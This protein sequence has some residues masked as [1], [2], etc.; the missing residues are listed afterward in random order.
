MGNNT[1]AERKI[2]SLSVVNDPADHFVILTSC[3]PKNMKS[4]AEIYFQC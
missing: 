4:K 2:E 3:L 1:I